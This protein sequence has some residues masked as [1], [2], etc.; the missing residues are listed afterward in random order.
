LKSSKLY[1]FYFVKNKSILILAQVVAWFVFIFGPAYLFS[2]LQ[3]MFRE[4]HFHP[5]LVGIVV[6]HS[7]LAAFY[8]FNYYKLLPDY[9]FTKRSG[10]YFLILLVCLLILI[11]LSFART[12]FNPFYGT[13]IQFKYILFVFSV[14]VRFILVTLIGIGVSGYS[15][16]K[17][18]EEEKLKSELTYLKA[19]INPHFLFNTL[20]S[21]YALSVKKSDVAPESITKL[22]S[23]MRYVIT[24][25]AQDLVTLEKEMDY[26]SSYIELEKLR[27]TSKVNLKYEVSEEMKGKQIAPLIFIPFIE[28]AFKYGVSTSENSNISITLTLQGNDLTLKVKNNKMMASSPK[29]T[30]RLGIETTKKRLDMIYPGKYALNIN[31]TEKE[32]LVDLKITLS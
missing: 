4:G 16:L 25:A 14:V 5:A 21:I 29:K 6:I 13:E 9:Y 32:F 20:N 22:S 27:L 15:R 19:Q 23:I 18:A 2:T 8:Y 31:E 26:V 1:Y 17:K 11:L 12:D 28:N 3:P 30:T 7:A 10:T 24:D